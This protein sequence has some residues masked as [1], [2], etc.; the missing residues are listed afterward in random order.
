MATDAVEFDELRVGAGC[1]KSL[2]KFLLLVNREQD[3]GT[4]ADHEH[5]LELQALEALFQRAAI[6]GQVEQVRCVRQV[7][8]AVGV[9]GTRELAGCILEVGLDCKLTNELALGSPR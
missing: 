6:V 4:H 8:I 3:I 9:E 1:R 2:G 7:E 5:A